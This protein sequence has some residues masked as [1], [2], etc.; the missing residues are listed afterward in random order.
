MTNRSAFSSTHTQPRPDQ[1][2][3][4]TQNN[5]TT[6]GI[7][8]QWNQA[9]P[10]VLYGFDLQSESAF[11]HAELWELKQ[12]EFVCGPGRETLTADASFVGCDSGAGV[13]AS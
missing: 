4:N 10:A 7:A 5:Q 6:F 13:L 3:A 2:D 8:I 1:A 12:V 9:V 11:S